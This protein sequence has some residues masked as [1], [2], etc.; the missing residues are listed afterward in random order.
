MSRGRSRYRVTCENCSFIDV[1]K[2]HRE[3]RFK[4]HQSFPM[5]WQIGD[6]P[7]GAIEVRTGSDVMTLRFQC[8]DLVS[9]EW[10]LVEQNVPIAWTKCALGGRR[11]WFVCNFQINSAQR[12]QRRA[13][14]IYLGANP[15]FACREC[16]GLSYASQKQ[17]RHLRVI[18]K[19]MK[20]RMRLGGSPNLF[21][22][23]PER[24]KGLHKITYERMRK[25]HDDADSQLSG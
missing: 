9:S 21:A 14:R 2:L 4:V 3:G 24:P 8:Q 19:A 22:P 16:Q 23:F 5:A 17:T 11:P 6:E 20:I 18:S 15:A 25:I 12:C 7:L 1:R 10:R 13:A